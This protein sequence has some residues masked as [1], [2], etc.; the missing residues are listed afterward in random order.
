MEIKLRKLDPN[1]WIYFSN[2]WRDKELIALTSGDFTLLSDQEIQKQ[3]N[4]I[5]IDKNSFH[6]MIKA[7]GKTVGHINLNK[8]GNHKAE[9]QIVIG[10]KDY[11]GR[12]IGNKAAKE[13]LNAAKQL[14]FQKIKIEVRPKNSRAINL[15]HK[16]GFKNLGL[17]K[18]PGNS[19]LPEVIMMEKEI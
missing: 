6:F 8:L 2:W 17:K 7:D 5:T 15:Y 14:G 10:E 1:D 4:E 19:N 16:L 18:Y 11:W 9:L 13:I 3:V 12:G